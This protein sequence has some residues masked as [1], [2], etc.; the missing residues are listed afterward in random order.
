V[1]RER[2]GT[3]GGI[4]T[5]KYKER[6]KKS[7]PSRFPANIFPMTENFI[8]LLYVH[9]YAK[10]Q[11]F[12]QLSLILKK[13]C[14]ITHDHPVNFYISQKTCKTAISLHQYNQSPRNLTRWCRTCF[15][16]AW[17]LETAFEI[18]RWQ[19]TTILKIEKLQYFMMMWNGSLKYIGVPPSW[20]FKIKFLTG[21]ALER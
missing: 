18:P 7:T 3:D 16:N 14:Q 19:T 1:T 15:W 11:N 10:L 4:I 8:C 5:V 12:I 21:R 13:L 17:L 6:H 9:I 20:I 2:L